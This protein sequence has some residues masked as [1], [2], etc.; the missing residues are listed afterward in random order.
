M[1]PLLEDL[2]V[3]KLRCALTY[4]ALERGVRGVRG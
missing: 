1:W 4:L 3:V 2:E